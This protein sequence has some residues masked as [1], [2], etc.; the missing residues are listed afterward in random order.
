MKRDSSES[1]ENAI[2]WLICLA[3]GVFAFLLLVLFD[4][5]RPEANSVSVPD[6]PKVSAVSENNLPPT[7]SGY[8]TVDQNPMPDRSDAL[9]QQLQSFDPRTGKPYDMPMDEWQNTLRAFR[10]TD[11]DTTQA[12]KEEAGRALWYFHKQG[13]L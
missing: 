4:Q 8:S 6:T 13:K 1:F 7:N 3:F 10:I 2:A 12:E 5:Q 9:E 11:P